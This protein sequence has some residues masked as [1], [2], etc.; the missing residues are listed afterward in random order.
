MDLIVDRLEEPIPDQ[1]LILNPKQQGRMLYNLFPRMLEGMHA[2]AGII[3]L[4][5]FI[6]FV[7]ISG[8]DLA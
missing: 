2:S 8:T 6:S 7:R 5:S 3:D 4:S 1:S